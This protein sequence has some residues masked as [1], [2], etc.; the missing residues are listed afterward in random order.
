MVKL[1][2]SIIAEV[3]QSNM[4]IE[5]H[6]TFEV[7]SWVP[8]LLKIRNGTLHPY[9]ELRVYKQLQQENG[10]NQGNQ[11]MANIYRLST[12]TKSCRYYM[13]YVHNLDN[14][15]KVVKAKRPQGA[16]QWL[17]QEYVNISMHEH[18]YHNLYMKFKCLT[19][20]WLMIK[21]RNVFPSH[22]SIADLHRSRKVPSVYKTHQMGLQ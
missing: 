13:K 15:E 10:Q 18:E 12:Q 19:W 6:F 22:V 11:S 14:S 8:C 3:I 2:T 21:S 16:N 4:E 7:L 5:M 9:L 20:I 17:A 1:N